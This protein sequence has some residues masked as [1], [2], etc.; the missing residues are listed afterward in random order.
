MPQQQQPWCYCHCY[1]TSLIPENLEKN[2]FALRQ[3]ALVRL[4]Y[5]LSAITQATARAALTHTDA[6]LATVRQVMDQRDR[7]VTELTA[8]GL[9]VAGSDANFVLFGHLTDSHVVW[10]ELLDR[11]V[12]IRD[13]GLP[14][15][16]R[17]TA[18]TPAETGAF[19][20][21]LRDTMKQRPELFVSHPLPQESS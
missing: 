9:D 18:G 17:V 13:V 4:P 11:D 19:L 6:L 21:A 8:M 12:L 15:R 5:H 10:Q 2:V 14:G 20:D 1:P 16:L 7:I 3:K